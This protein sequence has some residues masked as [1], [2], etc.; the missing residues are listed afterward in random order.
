MRVVLTV[1]ARD[2]QHALAVATF[3]DGVLG[4]TDVRDS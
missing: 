3:R 2:R 1:G 4:T